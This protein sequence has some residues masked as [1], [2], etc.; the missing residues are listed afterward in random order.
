MIFYWRTVNTI[1]R[2]WI[3]FGLADNL[4]DI[5]LTHRQY[6]LARVNTISVGGQFHWRFMEPPS[7]KFGLASMQ[8]S[9]PHRHGY[10]P[11]CS[12]NARVPVKRNY[13]KRKPSECSSPRLLHLN[14][15][16]GARQLRPHSDTVSCKVP[17]FQSKNA[18]ATLL[19]TDSPTVLYMRLNIEVAGWTRITR[20]TNINAETFT[21]EAKTYTL[22][23]LWD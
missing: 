16:V 19:C 17:G 22:Q 6:N 13:C 3:Q 14:N 15:K 9:W 20:Q 10:T 4:I 8:F 23:G 21:N 18:L 7:I 1:W 2:M 11:I 5:L 12:W